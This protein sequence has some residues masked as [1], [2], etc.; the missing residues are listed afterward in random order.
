MQSL[1]NWN[2]L[3]NR[4]WFVRLMADGTG[5]NVELYLTQANASARVNRRAYGV[6]L[7][8]GSLQEVALFGDNG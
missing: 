4:R 2:V 3:E 8:H 1:D 7:G 5:V 6:S